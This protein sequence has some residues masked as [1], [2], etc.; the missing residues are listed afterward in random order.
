M[1]LRNAYSRLVSQAQEELGERDAVFQ[2]VEIEAWLCDPP[3]LRGA[4]A[5]GMGERMYGVQLWAGE[6][7]EADTLKLV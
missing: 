4:T 7:T 2:Y 5:D 3:E 1:R 6:S